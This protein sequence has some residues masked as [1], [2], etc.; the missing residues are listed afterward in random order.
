MRLVP[1][2]P[3]TAAR[4]KNGRAASGIQDAGLNVVIERCTGGGWALCDGN[5]PNIREHG[6]LFQLIST[7]YGGDEQ[8][9][10]ALPNLEPHQ[11]VEFYISLDGLNQTPN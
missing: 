9:I 1:R 2:R 7:T 6:V 4:R 3:A 10:Y 8:A 5:L 11:R